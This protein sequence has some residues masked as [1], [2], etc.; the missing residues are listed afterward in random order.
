MIYNTT[1]LLKES[2]TF[3]MFPWVHFMTTPQGDVFPCCVGVSE[4]PMT[5]LTSDSTFETVIN[6]N[7]FK[8]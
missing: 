6:S 2:K 7:N 4:T 8:K 5:K 3:C 1:Y